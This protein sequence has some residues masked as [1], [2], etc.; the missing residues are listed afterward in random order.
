MILIIPVISNTS[1]LLNLAAVDELTVLRSQFEDVVVPQAV[2]DELRID[3]EL[4][5][6]E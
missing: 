2:V 3:E 4:P 6:N 5:G 1:P